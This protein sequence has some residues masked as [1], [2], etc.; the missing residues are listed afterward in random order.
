MLKIDRIEI[1]DA[2]G[3]PRKLAASIIKQLP[4][5]NKA[6]P[7]CS[8]AKAIDIHNIREEHLDGIEGALIVPENKAEGEILVNA[9]L[10]EERRRYT[11]AHEIGHYVN[12]FHIANDPSGF[13]CTRKDMQINNCASYDRHSKMEMEANSFAADLLMPPERVKAFLS[14]SAG[15]ELTEILD[16]A[17][18]FK[19]S[20]EAAARRYLS[21][22]DD[23]TAIIFS[24][25]NKIR[26]IKTTGDEFPR[27]SVWNKDQLP[28]GS[29]SSRSKLDIGEVSNWSEVSGEFWLDNSIRRTVLEQTIYQNNGYRMTL[30]NVEM[31]DGDD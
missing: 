8:I 12:P 7:V 14:E 11:I 2:G 21:Y 10:S 23:H 17:M 9:K 20:K 13:R 31:E 5:E 16:L 6:I 27:L 19:V 24:K 29:L 22:L 25:D 28:Q 26:Y 15:P 18:F 3:N 4:N 1:D 30:L